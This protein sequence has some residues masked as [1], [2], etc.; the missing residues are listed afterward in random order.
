MEI[1]RAR[2]VVEEHRHA[3]A[4]GLDH[5]QVCPAATAVGKVLDQAGAQPTGGEV[6]HG[7]AGELGGIVLPRV[8]RRIAAVVPAHDAHCH[9]RAERESFPSLHR[10]AARFRH[11]LRDHLEAG[12]SRSEDAGT[13]ELRPDRRVEGVVEVTVAAQ[14]DVHRA[15]PPDRREHPRHDRAVGARG[16]P[17]AQQVACD[18]GALRDARQISIDE[19]AERADAE[20]KVGDRQPGDVGRRDGNVDGRAGSPGRSARACARVSDEERAVREDTDSGTAA[21]ARHASI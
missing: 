2:R 6:A 5:E 15:G 3:P 17:R 9:P 13:G 21:A 10:G 16:G 1:D 8:H 4:V 14:H 18:E 19:D 12:R 7:C 11:V 20:M